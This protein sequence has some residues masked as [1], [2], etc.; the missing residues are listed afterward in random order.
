MQGAVKNILHVFTSLN[1]HYRADS[2]TVPILQ[3]RKLR[4]RD[5]KEL[6]CCYNR[7]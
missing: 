3:I 2:V 5:V 1:S 4:L 7:Q 6:V